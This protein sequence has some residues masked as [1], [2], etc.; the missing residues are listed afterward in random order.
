MRTHHLLLAA[1]LPSSS[2]ALATTETFKP[3]ER[4]MHREAILADCQA[5]TVNEAMLLEAG[6]TAT[7]ILEG[8]PLGLMDAVDLVLHQTSVLAPDAECVIVDGRDERPFEGAHATL[9]RG[10]IADEAWSDVFLAHSDAG[11]FGWIETQEERWIITSGHPTGDR[12][13]VIYPVSGI[14]S[15]LIQWTPWECS[16]VDREGDAP[17]FAGPTPPSGGVAGNLCYT[18]DIAIDT[19]NEFLNEFGGNESQAQGYL[20]TLVAGANFIYTRDA[21]TQLTIV[22]SRLWSSSDPWS[23]GSAGGRLDELQTYWTSNMGS[24]SRD[25]THMLSCASL[26]GGVAM[27]IGSVCSNS[28]SYAVSGS[29][30]GY[31]PNP[32]QAHS[33]QNWDIMVFTHELGHLFNS[34]HTH[35]YNPP[36]DGCGNGD[37]SSAF[38]GT[39]MSYCHQCSGG[40]NNIETTFHPTVQNVIANYLAGRPCVSDTDCGAVDSDGDGVDDSIDNCPDDAN[41]NQQDSDNDGAGDACDGCPNDPLKTEPGD[42]GCGTPDVDNDGDGTSD[43]LED[44]FNVP[45][46]YGSIGE[47]VD[48]AP[49][50]AT[51]QVAA[52]IWPVTEPINLQ[53]KA[54]TILGELDSGGVPATIVRGNGSTRIFEIDNGETSSTML[55]QLRIEGGSESTGAGLYINNASPRIN[56]CVF[57]L[58]NATNGGAIYIRG[59][60]SSPNISSCLFQ[61]NTATDR[62]GAIYLRLAT[63]P[64]LTNCVF[65]QNLA[66][67]EGGAVANMGTDAPEVLQSVFCGNVPDALVGDWNDNG[68]NCE[69]DYCDDTDGDGQADAC[70]DDTACIGDLNGNGSVDGADLGIFLASFGA[71]NP[72]DSD[73]DGD[74]DAD[75]GDLGLL[76]ASWGACP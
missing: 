25:T 52:G 49:N 34:P 5:I 6:D 28:W 71:T 57:T 26:G 16:T 9:W 51:I 38:G 2:L 40:M 13:T 48:A 59:N 21:S 56:A 7:C 14:A 1:L 22:Y 47:A 76:L 23:S 8:V 20:E 69:S 11:L 32:I 27:T 72:G 33:S 3:F 4:L 41:S 63:E 42:C 74:G 17:E 31:F 29:L 45:A 12:T 24:V 60:S 67:I 75:G 46:N 35:S 73:L 64:N 53:G 66:G 10:H 61:S 54:I 30:N 18:V 15:A 50:G 62:G 70:G 58:N 39:I 55:R 68:G 37:C 19:D 65:A 43:C 44:D 36:I